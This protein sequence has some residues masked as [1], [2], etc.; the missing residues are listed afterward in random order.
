MVRVW[1]GV[2]A[3]SELTAATIADYRV[4][5]HWPKVE[6]FISDFTGVTD[7]QATPEEI[8]ELSNAEART[9]AFIPNLAM[10][11]VAPTDFLF[12]MARMWQVFAQKTGWSLG[13]FRSRPEAEDWARKSG[14]GPSDTQK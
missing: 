6:Y 3:A 2:V 9:S 1:T 13:V 11:V 8:R 4:R 12:G 7:L 14:R 5:E 10:A